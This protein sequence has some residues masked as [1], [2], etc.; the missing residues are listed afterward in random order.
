[1]RDI[2]ELTENVE[3][4]KTALL[5]KSFKSKKN[6]VGYVILNS[7]PRILKWYV[8]GLRQNMDIEYEVL[9]KG[10]SEI[11]MPSPLEKDIENNVLVMS[12]IQ[13]KNVCDDLNDPH[14]DP[15]EKKKIAALLADWLLAFHTFF[16]TE[17]D[18]RIR[19]DPSLRNFIINRNQVW[20]L[21]FE[22]SRI[23][24]P[25]EDLAGIYVS[26]LSSEP[27]FTEE[28]FHLGQIL[29]DTYRKSSKWDI[30]NINAEIS[31]GLLERIQWRPKDEEILRKYAIKI[32][33]KGLHA[34]RHNY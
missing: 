3:K 25:V 9:K 28:K 29:L 34:A 12:Y 24:K 33:Q 18:F 16:K 22:E 5:Q 19:G 30:E 2:Q 11:S 26:I 21:D 15:E 13:G 14:T 23:G 17:N 7:Q 32:R 8:P 4:Y 6:T 31:Y 1:M 27:M 20:G 10:F